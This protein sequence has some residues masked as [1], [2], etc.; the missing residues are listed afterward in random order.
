[1]THITIT[2]AA[3]RKACSRQ[4][5]YA[6]VTRRDI[7]ADHPVAGG[8]QFIRADETFNS[9]EPKRECVNMAYR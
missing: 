1:M 5:I 4:T 7:Y 9:W 3:R 6:A 8:P 2:E